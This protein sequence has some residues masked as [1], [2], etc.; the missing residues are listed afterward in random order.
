MHRGVAPTPSQL[1]GIV[2]E[3]WPAGGQPEGQLPLPHTTTPTE[4]LQLD[5]TTNKGNSGG[6]VIDPGDGR[7]VGIISSTMG[8]VDE[9]LAALLERKE[10]ATVHIAGVNPVAA[11]K[12]IVIDM[13][14]HLQLGVAYGISVRHLTEL[15]EQQQMD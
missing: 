13:T 14:R 12:K 1:L 15:L 10:S 11:L 2:V 4:C 9:E 8:A 5:G 3:E 6:P 7:V